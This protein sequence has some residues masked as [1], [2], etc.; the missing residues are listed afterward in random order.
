[1]GFGWI[2]DF[3]AAKIGDKL[4]GIL[5]WLSR[6]QRGKWGTC[7]PR[8]FL[9]TVIAGAPVGQCNFL[10]PIQLPSLSPYTKELRW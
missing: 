10:G 9:K 4:D 8:Q 1:M 3:C 2:W 5:P 7:S 6:M